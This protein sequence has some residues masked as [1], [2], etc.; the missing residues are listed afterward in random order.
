MMS[1]TRSIKMNRGVAGGVYTYAAGQVVQDCP[2][3]RAA[4]LVQAGHAVY[5]DAS[6]QSRAETPESKK[7]I[8]KR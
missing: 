7:R 3:D 8:E 6:P 4:D 5:L 2:E 1:K